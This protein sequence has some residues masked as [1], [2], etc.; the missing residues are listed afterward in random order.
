MLEYTLTLKTEED[1]NIIKKLLKAFD[2][3]RIYPREKTEYTIE[4]AFD[5]VKNGDV[6]GPFN[7][8][9]DFMKDLLS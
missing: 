2:G 9:E 8:V 7:S 1:Y 3:A 4:D 5:E 6:V